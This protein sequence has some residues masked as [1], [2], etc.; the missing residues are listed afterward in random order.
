MSCETTY[1][2]HMSITGYYHNNYTRQQISIE[3]DIVVFVVDIF[4]VIVVGKVSIEMVIVVVIVDDVVISAVIIIS[5]I[6]F[7]SLLF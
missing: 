6:V 1:N 7:R 3:M 5:L 2:R 4:V